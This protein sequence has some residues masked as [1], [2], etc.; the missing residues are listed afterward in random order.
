[1]T[2]KQVT[3]A[4][5]ETSRLR[6]RGLLNLMHKHAP[7]QYSPYAK[8]AEPIEDLMSFGSKTVSGDSIGYSSK[9][10]KGLKVVISSIGSP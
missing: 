1:M 4:G 10:P 8:D 3:P 2:P 9:P 6:L 7:M 5:I